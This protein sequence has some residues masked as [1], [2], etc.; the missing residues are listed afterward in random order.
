MR[1]RTRDYD[2]GCAPFRK[3]RRTEDEFYGICVFDKPE[4]QAFDLRFLI[5]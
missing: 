2:D 4:P 1:C 5:A 3:A